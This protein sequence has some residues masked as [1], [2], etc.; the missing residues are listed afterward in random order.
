MKSHVP[1]GTPLEHDRTILLGSA[2]A[3]A[4]TLGI[5]PSHIPSSSS[6]VSTGAILLLQGSSTRFRQS[7]GRLQRLKDEESCEPEHL[8]DVQSKL[9]KESES[10]REGWG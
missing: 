2:L 10:R 8:K 3:E 5:T 9:P 4:T 6:S 1:R 7:S